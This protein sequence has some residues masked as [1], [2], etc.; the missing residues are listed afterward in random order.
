MAGFR[1]TR[2][3]EDYVFVEGRAVLR[4]EMAEPSTERVAAPGE[5]AA[6]GGLRGRGGRIGRAARAGAA[7]AAGGESVRDALRDLDGRDAFE[8]R[9]DAAAAIAGSR[10]PGAQATSMVGSSFVNTETVIAEDRRLFRR[11]VLIVGGALLV[12]SLFSLCISESYYFTLN[13]PGDVISCIGSWF[14]LMFVRI[15]DYS[16]FAQAQN[17][18]VQNLPMYFDVMAEVLL[19][20]KYL[21][22]GA[23]LA[24]SGMLYQNVFR[25]PIAAPS[26]LGVTNGINLALLILVLQLGVA[27]RTRMDLYYLYAYIGGAAILVLVI[28]GSRMMSGKG[29]FSVVNMILIGTVLSQMIGVFIQYVE[30]AYM[31]DD[32]VY[33]YQLL[34]MASE[35]SNVW[36]F[37]TLGV[38]F[39]VS[40]VPIVALRFRLNLLSFDDAEVRLLGADP[41]KL[42]IVALA[43]GSIMILTA[44]VNAGQVAMASLVVPFLARAVFGSEFRKQLLGSV[45]LGALV[46]LVCGDV[47]NYFLVYIVPLDL[48]SVV[49]VLA[50][51][52]FVWMLV[53]Q[54]R[55]WE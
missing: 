13:A 49:T 36:T 52:L 42:R 34:Q 41:N 7:G 39:V 55:T 10:T 24:I 48:G 8:L 30:V 54:Q 43:C 2:E 12:L 9:D 14:Y 6:Q 16:Q 33:A 17:Q 51:P 23:L 5:Q 11:K 46:L 20:I 47:V 28:L 18:V 3:S 21:A 26:M 15:T 45:L 50:L 53:I 38:G 37:A 29:T 25:N 22:C 35:Q 1:R 27:A 19:V 40:L 4:G 32:V 44:Q 31:T